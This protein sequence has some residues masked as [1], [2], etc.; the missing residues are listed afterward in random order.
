MYVGKKKKRRKKKEF[1]NEKEKK[2][3]EITNNDTELLNCTRYDN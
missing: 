2:T 1:E 3:V